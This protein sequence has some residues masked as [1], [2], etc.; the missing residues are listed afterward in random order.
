M[1]SFPPFK[2]SL[3]GGSGRGIHVT[4]W[5]I[6]VNVWQNPQ[7]CC[8]VISLQ[9]IKINEKKIPLWKGTYVYLRLIHV[10]VWQ[11][12]TKFCEAIIILQL[13]NKLTL[14]IPLLYW[15]IMENNQIHICSCSGAKSCLT[16]CDPMDC[17]L[18]GSS[19]HGIFPARILEGVVIEPVSP[20]LAQ[21]IY[22][23]V[24][25]SVCVCVCVWYIYYIYIHIYR[26]HGVAKSCTQ[27]KRLSRH[28]YIYIYTY[29]HTHIYM[30]IYIYI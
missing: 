5:L 25:L 20:A 11:K 14:K 22:M 27:L 10:D 18:P 21:Y 1:K 16:L 30:H 19:V 2:K 29:T 23:C 26:V 9:L 6:Y 17:S 4:P 7:K 8:E 13:K 15:P 12:T 28:T 24:H 3:S